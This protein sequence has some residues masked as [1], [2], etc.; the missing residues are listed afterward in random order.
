MLRFMTWKRWKFVF[1]H[2][3]VAMVISYTMQF[4][5]GAGLI[6]ANVTGLLFLV[7]KEIGEF[8]GKKK[9]AGT[10]VN[11][12]AGNVAEIKDALDDKWQ[13]M[14]TVGASLISVGLQ[15]L[16]QNFL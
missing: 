12:F 7:A 2:A 13:L 16:I 14:Q 6:E 11:D 15:Y 10:F 5:F 9:A 3:I 8:T 4:V 1:S